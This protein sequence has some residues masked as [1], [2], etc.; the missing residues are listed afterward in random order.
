VG[1]E[2]YA[3]L[4]KLINRS[5]GAHGRGLVHSIGRV[6][7]R[8]L[9]PWIAKRV[10]PGTYQPTLEEMVGILSPHGFA[11]LDVENLRLHYVKTLEHWLERYEKNAAAIE[12]RLDSRFARTWRM[13]LAGSIA[14][15]YVGDLQ[16]WQ[17]V[18]AREGANDLPWTRAG[19]YAAGR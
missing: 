15:F 1:D 9:D 2:N 16:L 11:T 17:V 6:Q 10:F 4:G 3:A 8:A 19:L 12:Q 7:R 13:Y 18:F 5:L 14:A